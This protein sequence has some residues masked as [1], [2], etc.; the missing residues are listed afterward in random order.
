MIEGLVLKALLTNIDERGFFREI[1][2]VADDFFAEG[3]GQ[4]SHSQVTTINRL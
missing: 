4:W 2:R 1:I 3:L